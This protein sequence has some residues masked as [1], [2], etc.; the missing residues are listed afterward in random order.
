MGEAHQR[1]GIFYTG[2]SEARYLDDPGAYLGMLDSQQ[3]L[4]LRRAIL[5]DKSRVE[6]PPETVSP[7]I[8]SHTD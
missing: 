7:G 8:R 3:L 2:P 6:P 1:Q 4:K 5:V